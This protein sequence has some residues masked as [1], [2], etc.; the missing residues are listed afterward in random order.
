MQ[1]CVVSGVQL[2]DSVIHKH[3]SILFQVI[4]PC[5]LV[6]NIE[7]SSL[8]YTGIVY[9]YIYIYIYRERERERE[10]EIGYLLIIYF[11]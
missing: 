2:S 9:I 6:Q 4:F 1:Y 8:C 3:I 10:R 11:I 5:K 7:Q